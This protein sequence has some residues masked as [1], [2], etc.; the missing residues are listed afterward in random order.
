M[1]DI[2]AGLPNLR[3]LY[4][5]GNPIVEAMRN[6]RKTVISK[7]PGL[8]YLDERPIFDLERRCAEAWSV[9]PGGR[10]WN[11]SLLTAHLFWTTGCVLWR[12][13]FV[14]EGTFVSASNMWATQG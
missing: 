12:Y 13:H 1:L 6:Y 11:T 5:K 14:W 8:T 2:F 3:C 9:P 7:L 10:I 4:L